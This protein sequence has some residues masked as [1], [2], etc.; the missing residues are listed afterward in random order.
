MRKAISLTME[1]ALVAASGSLALAQTTDNGAT[2]T[3]PA[4][5]R[6]A[7]PAASKRMKSHPTGLNQNSTGSMN[8]KGA[9]RGTT[10]TGG[11]GG[12]GNE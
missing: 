1:A 2:A 5:S 3:P 6:A 4:N 11:P 7:P 8:T 10:G 12:S 9:G